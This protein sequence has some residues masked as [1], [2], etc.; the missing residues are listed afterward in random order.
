VN[1]YFLNNAVHLLDD[2][3]SRAKP[4][5][6]GKISYGSR[7]DHGWRVLSERQL[8]D[9]MAATIEKGRRETERPQR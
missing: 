6:E 9:E 5:Y 2:F 3:L 1:D 8:M 4:A 7:G